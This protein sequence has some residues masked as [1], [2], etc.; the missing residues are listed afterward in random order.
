MPV[1]LVT[2]VSLEKR[3]ARAAATSAGKS[4]GKTVI[5]HER[6]TADPYP[7]VKWRAAMALLIERTG[8]TK[9]AACDRVGVSDSSIS[10]YANGTR[11]PNAKNG[12]RLIIACRQLF[13]K[14]ELAE[15]GIDR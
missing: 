12:A 15:V 11:R 1:P 13:S 10:G 8:G 9:R 14:A 6:P 2:P 4:S 7:G 3:T 5:A